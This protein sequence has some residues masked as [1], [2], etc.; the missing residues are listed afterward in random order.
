MNREVGRTAARFVL[1]AVLVVAG[2]GHLT[3]QRVE[4]RAQVPTWFP[5]DADVV[6][7]V[8]G[9]VEILLGVALVVAGSHAPVVGVVAAAFFVLIFPGNIAQFLEHRD[10]FGL[11]SDAKRFVRL[12]FQP[13]LVLW[14][15]WST[16]GWRWLRTTWRGEPPT[17]P[18]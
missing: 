2:V 13:V 8:S 14:A 10:A 9:V 17:S 7:L 11:D 4:F 6:V 16:G 1:G 3:A 12:W 5:V 18:E 15:L